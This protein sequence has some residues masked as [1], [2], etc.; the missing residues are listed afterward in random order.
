MW[1][2][3][4]KTTKPSEVFIRERA[5]DRLQAARE[6]TRLDL[7]TAEVL[8]DQNGADT[9][10]WKRVGDPPASWRLPDVRED[11]TM[12]D[13]E[14][15]TE[16]MTQPYGPPDPLTDSGVHSTNS[17]PLRDPCPHCFGT[18][19][20]LTTNEILRQ[21]LSLLGDDPKGHHSVV[22]EFYRRLLLAAPNLAALFPADLTDPLSAGEG[23]NQRDRLLGALL[24]VG[25]LYDPDHPDSEAMLSLHQKIQTWGRAHAAFQR[26]NGK[27]R[28][29]SLK[30]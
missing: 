4:R 12:P 1:P 18:G 27:V 8:F 17:A 16:D 30:E 15:P 26:P 2:F 11:S 3:R 10:A 19:K 5:P 6:I 21:S 13:T 28:P 24:D 14:P 23:K 9:A 22:A 20:V 7:A 29:A 25:S